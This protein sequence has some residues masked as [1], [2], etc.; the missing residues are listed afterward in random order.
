M[1]IFGKDKINSMPY[2]LIETDKYSF[3]IHAQ[4]NL[5]EYIIKEGV[6]IDVVDI[7]EGKKLL[8]KAKPNTKFFVLAEGIEFF[9]LTKGARELSATKEFSDNTHAIAFYTTNSS[10]LLLGEIYNKINK[11]VVPTKIFN[12]RD[13]AM[14]WLIQQMWKY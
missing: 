3:R 8:T 10:L 4:N 13:E 12:D 7:I 2:Q 14:E 11:P 6:T 1:S 9:T 5:L